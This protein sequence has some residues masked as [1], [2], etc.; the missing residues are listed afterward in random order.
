M[1]SVYSF[2]K[3]IEI[4][5][6]VFTVDMR[7]IKASELRKIGELMAEAVKKSKNGFMSDEDSLPAF[8]MAFD[9]ILGEGAFEKIFRETGATGKSC[10][11]LLVFLVE[12]LGL[13]GR[14]NEQKPAKK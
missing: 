3:E 10:E 13:N 8:K 1:K 7:T 12:E 6:N 4:D 11:D 5:G 9:C 14:K 2:K